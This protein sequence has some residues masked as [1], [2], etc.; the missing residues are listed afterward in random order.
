MSPPVKVVKCLTFK[1]IMQA[2][3][4]KVQK[5]TIREDNYVAIITNFIEVNP[6]SIATIANM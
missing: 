6:S 5:I 1:C 3:D 2:N 4:K